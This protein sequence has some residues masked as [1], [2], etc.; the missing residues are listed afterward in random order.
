MNK[1]PYLGV[2]IS[3][4]TVLIV[5]TANKKQTLIINQQ[6]FVNNPRSKEADKLAIYNAWRS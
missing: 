2:N 1:S 3:S 4:T 6:K 5:E